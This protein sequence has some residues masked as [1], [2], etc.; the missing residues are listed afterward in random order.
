MSLASCA[1]L[2][3]LADAEASWF[4]SRGQRRRQ[5]V[6]RNVLHTLARDGRS[7]QAWLCGREKH[8][9]WVL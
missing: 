8:H 1:V 5:N 7:W 6:E 3:G 2:V 4:R 9:L